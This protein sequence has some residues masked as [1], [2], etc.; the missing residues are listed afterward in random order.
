MNF[1]ESN[2][3]RYSVIL[4]LGII[5]IA[6]F[7]IIPKLYS[8]NLFIAINLSYFILGY[9]SIDW[10]QA[11]KNIFLVTIPV[12]FFMTLIFLIPILI[13]GKISNFIWPF[14]AALQLWGLALIVGFPIFLFGFGFRFVAL[15]ILKRRG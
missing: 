2:Y 1:F 5:E 9:L 14:K 11:I 15:L 10:R 7:M 3:I 12:F 13:K 6:S 8:V 4:L